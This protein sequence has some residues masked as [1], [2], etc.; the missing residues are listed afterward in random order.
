[1]KVWQMGALPINIHT[2]WCDI[3]INNGENNV[4]K[5]TGAPLGYA[6][7]GLPQLGRDDVNPEI[8]L[9]EGEENEFEKEDID[10]DEDGGLG[11]LVAS[12]RRTVQLVRNAGPV[13]ADG[14]LIDV[15]ILI[16]AA[17]LGHGYAAID[18][19]LRRSGRFPR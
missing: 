3:C 5:S 17:S 19:N 9:D 14:S 15:R 2:C 12:Q 6:K 1:M 16:D 4:G 8:K 11:N 18:K 13:T 10:G 7:A